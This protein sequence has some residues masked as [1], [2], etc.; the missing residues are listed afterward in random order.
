MSVDSTVK[1]H[2]A[3]VLTKLDVFIQAQVLNILAGLRTGQTASS[4]TRTLSPLADGVDSRGSQDYESAGD[5]RVR[6][7]AFSGFKIE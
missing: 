6:V 3:R 1:T 4:R 7:D 5:Q 2:V